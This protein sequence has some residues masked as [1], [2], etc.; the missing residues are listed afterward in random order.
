V[1][2]PRLVDVSR[3]D[4]ATVGSS[5]DVLRYDDVP[6]S[7]SPQELEDVCM[8]SCKDDVP[9]D[10]EVAGRVSASESVACFAVVEEASSVSVALDWLEPDSL[11]DRVVS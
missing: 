2:Y 9:S 1:Q 5:S 4:V 6:V 8:P 7:V 11:P 10:E 3:D